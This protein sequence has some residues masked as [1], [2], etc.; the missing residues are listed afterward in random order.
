[1]PL[2]VNELRDT[3]R[4]LLKCFLSDSEREFIEYLQAKCFLISRLEAMRLGMLRERYRKQ[5]RDRL[6]HEGSVLPW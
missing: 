3:A 5:I 2:K 6:E 1:M 4:A